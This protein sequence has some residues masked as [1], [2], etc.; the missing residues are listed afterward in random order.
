MYLMPRGWLQ[1]LCSG[2]TGLVASNE[3]FRSRDRNRRSRRHLS[4]QLS[5]IT[6]P[7]T[8]RL[9][10]YSDFSPLCALYIKKV[11]LHDMPS[12]HYIPPCQINPPIAVSSHV[13]DEKRGSYQ[14]S[15]A[16]PA[17]AT[18][19]PSAAF[20]AYFYD[21]Q[22]SGPVLFVLFLSSA[23]YFFMQ[24]AHHDQVVGSSLY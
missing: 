19:P 11:A 3:M 14:R 24:S 1:V 9:F 2:S 13:T 10:N 22:N 7:P 17:R 16:P 23:F 6:S 5:A 20:C 12:I 18:R 15:T 4:T 21:Q 8:S